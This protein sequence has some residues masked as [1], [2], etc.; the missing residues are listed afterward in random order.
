MEKLRS[1]EQNR[2]LKG[3]RR[4]GSWVNAK[5]YTFFFNMCLLTHELFY[6]VPREWKV[7]KEE[8]F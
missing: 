2:Y 4:G 6:Y 5:T 8:G 7:E 1:T 3:T